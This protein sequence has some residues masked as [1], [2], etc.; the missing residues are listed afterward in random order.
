MLMILKAAILIFVVM[1]LSNILILYFKPNFKYGNS[2]NT[3]KQ[4]YTAQNQESD[5]LF[6]QYL[7]NWVANC[8]FF[9]P[10]WLWWCCSAM[11]SLPSVR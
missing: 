10:F 11:R 7:V 4:W 5:R 1:E 8:K 3:F 6:V 2:M 9:W